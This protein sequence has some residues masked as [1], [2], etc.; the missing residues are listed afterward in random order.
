AAHPTVRAC[1][2]RAAAF[3]SEVTGRSVRVAEVAIADAVG[4]GPRRFA[5]IVAER[6]HD[7]VRGERGVLVLEHVTSDEGWLLPLALVE[8]RL[9][10]HAPGVAV[11]AD[12]AQATGLWPVPQGFRGTYV[13]C[14]HKYA[15]GPAGCG[16][17]AFI[18]SS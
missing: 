11:V 5:E 8:R 10:T 13:G 6:V 17:V 9:N 4:S 18:G 14:F 2:R 1:V 3:W 16:F 7:A 15:D 12:G